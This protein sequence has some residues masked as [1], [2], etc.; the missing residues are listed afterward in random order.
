MTLLE[1][2]KFVAKANQLAAVTFHQGF[3]DLI[4]QVRRSGRVWINQAD[5]FH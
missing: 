5:F 3:D 2:G 1:P 4:Q